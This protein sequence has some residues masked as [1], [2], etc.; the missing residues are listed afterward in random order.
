MI[1]LDLVDSLSKYFDQ[2]L[3]TTILI[4]LWSDKYSQSLQQRRSETC[5]GAIAGSERTM[6]FGVI[7]LANSESGNQFTTNT[8]RSTPCWDETATRSSFAMLGPFPRTSAER[9]PSVALRERVCRNK[10]LCLGPSCIARTANSVILRRDFR[11]V[12]DNESIGWA[13]TAVVRSSFLRGPERKREKYWPMAK[14]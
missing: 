12:R 13:V 11:N 7:D 4:S 6:K 5:D 8:S 14:H 3:G 9:L 10:S 2:E 1:R